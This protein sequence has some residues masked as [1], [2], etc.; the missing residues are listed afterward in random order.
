M[1]TSSFSDFAKRAQEA[2]ELA[3]KTAEVSFFGERE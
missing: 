3:A 2:A 1:W